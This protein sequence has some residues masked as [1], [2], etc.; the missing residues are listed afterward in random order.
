MNAL[1]KI[2]PYPQSAEEAT[3]EAMAR[4]FTAFA[5]M[6]WQVSIDH[7]DKGQA[8]Q[9]MNM[10]IAYYGLAYLLREMPARDRD[11]VAHALWETWDS[12]MGVAVDLWEWMAEYGID[13]A[14]V[15]RI[16][17]Q[18]VKPNPEAGTQAGMGG[19]A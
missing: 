14:A 7:P 6:H 5:Q 10:A 3:A 17:D 8:R 1:D 16:A 18:V 12:G 2:A 9:S 13:P 11:R 4:H 15:A 19:A